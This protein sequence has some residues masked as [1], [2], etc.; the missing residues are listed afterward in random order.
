MGGTAVVP[1]DK[2]C[3]DSLLIH[4]EQQ[5]RVSMLGLYGSVQTK[6]LK[7]KILTSEK[8]RNNIHNLLLI[9]NKTTYISFKVIK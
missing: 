5:I 9:W 6:N 4:W 3:V 8:K 7:K 1:N 2:K